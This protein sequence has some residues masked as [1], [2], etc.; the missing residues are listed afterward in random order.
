MKYEALPEVFRN[1]R[2]LGAVPF[3]LVFLVSFWM[4]YKIHADY[5]KTTTWLLPPPATT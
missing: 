5:A 1:T 3:V 2:V 4:G